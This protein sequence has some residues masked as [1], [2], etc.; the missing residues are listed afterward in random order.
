MYRDSRHT[1]HPK[2]NKHVL[3]LHVYI[4]IYIHII[5][6]TLGPQNH[7]KCRFQSL[8]IWVI[9][10]KNEENI[11]FYTLYSFQ[12]TGSGEEVSQQILLRRL[13]GPR[14]LCPA[15]G[16]R[17]HLVTIQ[18]FQGVFDLKI[19][20]FWGTFPGTRCGPLGPSSFK[21]K[22]FTPEINGRTSTDLTGDGY[23]TYK[24][25]CGPL[26]LVG[27]TRAVLVL[28]SIGRINSSP[29]RESPQKRS[30]I[31]MRW[32]LFW[33][34]NRGSAFCEETISWFASERVFQIT[35][36]I[37]KMIVHFKGMDTSKAFSWWIVD[38]YRWQTGTV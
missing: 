26:Q 4:F 32:D 13:D 19:W 29:W 36:G 3:N 28:F 31:P 24:W 33:F 35:Q 18:A 10:P 30:T 34:L 6:D 1:L 11:G 15:G 2:K 12:P 20:L 25:S 9:I 22:F 14:A 7:E 21:W 37:L 27:G 16:L 17:L 23:H 5:Y 8:E 38:V